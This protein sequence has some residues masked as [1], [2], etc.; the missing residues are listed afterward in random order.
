METIPVLFPGELLSSPEILGALCTLAAF[1][2]L[3]ITLMVVGVAGCTDAGIICTAVEGKTLEKNIHYKRLKEK[4]H[5][6]RHTLKVID[7]TSKNQTFSSKRCH[8]PK[9]NLNTF[10]LFKADLTVFSKYIIH[11]YH[12]D[13]SNLSRPEQGGWT[14]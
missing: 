4:P 11:F 13:P 10:Y 7:N 1:A 9:N 3:F 5:T 14:Q 2:L 8:H 12:F 6:Q